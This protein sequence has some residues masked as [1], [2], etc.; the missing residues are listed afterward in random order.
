MQAVGWRSTTQLPNRNLPRS[1]L[2]HF[3]EPR[4]GT[5]ALSETFSEK[6][7]LLMKYRDIEYTVV[8]GIDVWKW[9]ASVSGVVNMGTRQ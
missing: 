5:Y 7:R 4:S 8:Q 3:E 9:T 2:R 6:A 1:F